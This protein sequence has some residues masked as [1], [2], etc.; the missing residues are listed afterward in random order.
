MTEVIKKNIKSAVFLNSFESTQSRQ[1]DK[2][3]ACEMAGIK[4]D[5]LVEV[6][7]SVLG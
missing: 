3:M 5:F 2:R 4:E 6:A 1:L 7:T